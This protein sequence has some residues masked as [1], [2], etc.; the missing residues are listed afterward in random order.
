MQLFTFI[1]SYIATHEARAERGAGLAE[2][3]LLLVLV[4]VAC[5]GTL[6]TLGTTISGAFSNITGSLN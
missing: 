4:A 2:Y 5:V 1:Q 3:G 6:T